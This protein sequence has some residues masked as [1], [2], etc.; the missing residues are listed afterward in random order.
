[1]SD[2][3]EADCHDAVIFPNARNGR[4]TSAQGKDV[5]KPKP[6]LS[7]WLHNVEWWEF[8][9]LGEIQ[10]STFD[11]WPLYGLPS[12]WEQSFPFFS[13]GEIL[14]VDHMERSKPHFYV[15]FYLLRT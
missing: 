15:L 5:G 7:G 10:Y 11:I 8:W 12:Y 13:N 14:G 2:S 3:A 1:M 9:T 4:S 6:P